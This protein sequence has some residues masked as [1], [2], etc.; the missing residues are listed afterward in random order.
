MS[1]TMLCPD[2]SGCGHVGWA[3]APE[4]CVNC[5]GQGD[6]PAHLFEIMAL[7]NLADLDEPVDDLPF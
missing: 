7:Q 3:D 5:L 1:D 4:M 2:C 6:V